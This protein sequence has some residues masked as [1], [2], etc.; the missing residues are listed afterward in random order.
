[1]KFVVVGYGTVGSATLAL[2]E[3]LEDTNNI[4]IID[5]YK[6]IG[7]VN[8][9]W[10]KYSEGDVYFICTHENNVEEAINE[11]KNKE[12]LIIVRSST[13]PSTIENL[14]KKLSR[15][16]CHFPSFLIERNAISTELSADRIVFGVC[17]DKHKK[18]LNQFVENWKKSN[19]YQDCPV[20]FTTPTTSE[21]IK[22]TVNSFLAT[23]ITFWNEIYDLCTKYNVDTSVVA[24]GVTTDNRIG[25][26]GTK[27]FNEPFDGKCLPKDINHTFMIS[28]SPLLKIVEDLNKKRIKLE[29]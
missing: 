24:S 14:S 17:C 18:L 4:G 1:M 26:Y 27:K 7:N 20:I 8:T 3:R 23:H 16:I 13:I 2:L 19:L 10:N 22:K 11:I 29:E 21:M 12:A 25:K 6:L 9:T 5:K 28:G 15:H